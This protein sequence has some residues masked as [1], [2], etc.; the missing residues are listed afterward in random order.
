MLVLCVVIVPIALP[1]TRRWLPA[2]LGHVGVGWA[3]ADGSSTGRSSFR[4]IVAAA[5]EAM[6]HVR[7]ME[8][9]MQP[10]TALP[11]NRRRCGRSYGPTWER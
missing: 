10:A 9:L 1:L 4:R 5:G 11:R 2:K 3:L 6:S 7:A 8:G